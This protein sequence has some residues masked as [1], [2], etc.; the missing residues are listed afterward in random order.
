MSSFFVDSAILLQRKD[1]M[2]KSIKVLASMLKEE[3]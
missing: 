2:S 1:P 3:S